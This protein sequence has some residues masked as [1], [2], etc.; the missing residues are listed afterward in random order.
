VYGR[1]EPIVKRHFEAEPLDVM[2]HD[3]G[4]YDAGQDRCIDHCRNKKDRCL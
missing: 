1:I 4:R 2:K 3:L